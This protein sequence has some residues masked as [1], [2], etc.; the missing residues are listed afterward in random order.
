MNQALPSS[1]VLIQRKIKPVTE[2]K[3]D[4]STA[5]NKDTWLGNALLTNNNL[6]NLRN[7]HSKRSPTPR[8][9]ESQP[10]KGS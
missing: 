4:A 1:V 5:I 10:N 2:K 6:E 9:I 7:L 3:G 8:P